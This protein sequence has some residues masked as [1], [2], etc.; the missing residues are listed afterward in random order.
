MNTFLNESCIDP[1]VSNLLVF[2]WPI[3]LPFLYSFSIKVTR[4]SIVSLPISSV[5]YDGFFLVLCNGVYYPH[6]LCQLRLHVCLL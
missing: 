2:W 4:F 6:V 1:H 3:T 5:L